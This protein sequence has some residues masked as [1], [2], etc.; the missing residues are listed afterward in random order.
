MLTFID[1][2]QDKVAP[3]DFEN[4]IERIPL[5]PNIEALN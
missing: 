2:P 5:R 3:E 1:K 4:L